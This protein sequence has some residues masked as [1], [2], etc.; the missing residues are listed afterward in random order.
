[1]LQGERFALS[2]KE[3]A[4]FAT[5]ATWLDEFISRP[6]P[7]LGRSGDVCPW[8]R[9]TLQLGRLFLA[10]IQGTEEA[11][12]DACVLSLLSAFRAMGDAICP[13]DTFCAIVTVFPQLSPEVGD[14]V[15]VATH[16][17]LKPVFLRNQM[18]LGEFYP[19]CEKH[20]LHTAD[21]RPLHAPH[22]LLVLRAMVEADLLFLTDRN[23]FVEAYLQTFGARGLQRLLE[24]LEAPGDRVPPDRIEALR[25]RAAQGVGAH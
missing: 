12:I 16:T 6:N 13:L 18:M 14:Q 8:T 1:M 20:G 2:P 7:A 19:S 15:I 17:R 25:E 3:Q 4:L 10:S 21:F 9:R 24:L 23:E 5:T 22:P 11:C